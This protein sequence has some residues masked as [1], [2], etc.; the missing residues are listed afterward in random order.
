MEAWKG[1]REG[2]EKAGKKGECEEEMNQFTMTSR[3]K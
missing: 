2:V 3:L 1:E